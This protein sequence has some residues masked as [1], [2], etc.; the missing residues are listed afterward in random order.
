MGSLVPRT[1]RPAL[2]GTLGIAFLVAL[3][4]ISAL[5][6]TNSAFVSPVDTV[7]A[8]T[9]LTT[10]PAFWDSFLATITMAGRGL[11]LA[12]VVGV[13]AGILIGWSR[14]MEHATRVP[15][16]F[17]KPIPPI[18][19]M[20]IAIL[21]L[22]PTQEMGEFLVFYGCVLPITYQTAN[23]VRETDPVA[24]DTARSYGMS[25][26]E[27]IVRIVLPST[28]AFIATAIRIA[29]PISL[30]VTVVAGMIGG[31]PGLGRDIGV[32]LGAGNHASLYALVIVL[33][34]LGLLVQQAGT[35]LE[36]RILKWHPAYR[37]E[38]T[39]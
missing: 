20:P 35:V 34:I 24:I 31:G 14:P 8:A 13:M 10:M 29:L 5:W 30:I 36:S 11:A 22:G 39:R 38:T 16:E 18:V 7:G 9:G 6:V 33:G 27:I 25:K 21:V 26:G 4:Q 23:G 12:A 32:A 3:W 1:L 15:M 19:I 17:L 2:L 37:L 28:S